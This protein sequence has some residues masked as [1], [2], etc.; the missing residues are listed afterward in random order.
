[1]IRR[2]PWLSEEPDH[3]PPDAGGWQIVYTGFILILLCFFIML[4]SFASLDHSRITQF[5]QSFAN[6]VSVFDGGRSLE[7]G[8]TVINA[9]AMVVDKEDPIALLFETVKQAGEQ[10]H[11]DGISIQ[12]SDRGVVV[13]LADKMLFESGKAALSPASHELLQKIGMIINSTSARIDIQGHTDD[14]PI[15]TPGFP[16]NWELSTAR[17]VN[18]L[19]Y[20]T[21]D[22]EVS[23]HRL[24]VVGLSKYHPL[25]PNTSTE[26]RARNRRVEIIFRPE[27]P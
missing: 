8:K 2:K 21:T 17:A 24:S 25:V 5:V 10:N 12:R 22:A 19:R 4:T 14:Q 9:D 1:M 23:S 6:A 15:R 26:N 7:P 13:T 16:S 11:L 27:S 20:L 3:H 18:V